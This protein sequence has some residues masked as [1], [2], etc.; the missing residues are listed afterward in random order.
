VRP[1]EPA[2]GALAMAVPRSTAA[3]K[4][5]VR[6][7]ATLG[8]LPAPTWTDAETTEHAVFPEAAA[9]RSSSSLFGA[10]SPRSNARTT[11]TSTI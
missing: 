8:A 2:I 6:A 9:P 7:D 3:A 5:A 4:L 11:E 1:G 10:T